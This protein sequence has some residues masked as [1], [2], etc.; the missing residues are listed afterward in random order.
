[1][2][3]YLKV[4]SISA[5]QAVQLESVENPA[6]QNLHQT[7][8]TRL[9]LPQAEQFFLGNALVKEEDDDEGEEFP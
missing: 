9:A 7:A 2:S 1:M 8:T 5:K 6:W 4:L 3:Q